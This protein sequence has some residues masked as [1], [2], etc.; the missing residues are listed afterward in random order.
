MADENSQHQLDRE[1]VKLF[2]ELFV[3]G[4]K[5]KKELPG[6]V[7]VLADLAGDRL[8]PLPEVWEREFV[9]IT[10]ATFDA[11]M[12][13][14]APRVL[15]EIEDPSQPGKQIPVELCFESINDFRPENIVEK[16]VSLE[17]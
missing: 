1:R 15:L 14:I 16:M 6:K 9:D 13:G 8:E 17:E 4:A 5:V 11:V 12:K 3:N 7:A 2:Y 10:E